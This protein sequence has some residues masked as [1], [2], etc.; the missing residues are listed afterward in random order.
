MTDEMLAHAQICDLGRTES[1]SRYSIRNEGSV[2]PKSWNAAR[3]WNGTRP[4][5]PCLHRI[6][7][8]NVTRRSNDHDLKCQMKSDTT[9]MADFSHIAASPGFYMG[10]SA[11]KLL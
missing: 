2:E 7:G 10:S 5:W 9:T 11:L 8:S 4:G 3:G 6:N 1:S